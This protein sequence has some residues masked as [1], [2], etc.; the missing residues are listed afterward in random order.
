MRKLL[1]NDNISEHIGIKLDIQSLRYSWLNLERVP[2]KA[3]I[4]RTV[5]TQII[6]TE[7]PVVKIGAGAAVIAVSKLLFVAGMHILVEKSQRTEAEKLHY[8]PQRERT[9]V[10]RVVVP[11]K[12]TVVIHLDK[13][14]YLV[15]E[16]LMIVPEIKR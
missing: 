9:V 13:V 5:M 3:V 8:H 16:L 15:H 12:F 2:L 10:F 14:P 11:H 4:V 7:Q 1:Q 6:D